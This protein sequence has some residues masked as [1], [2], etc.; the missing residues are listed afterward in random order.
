MTRARRACEGW[1]AMNGRRHTWTLLLSLAGACEATHTAPDP[2][3]SDAAEV[4]REDTGSGKADV[5]TSVALDAPDSAGLERASDAALD[6]TAADTASDAGADAAPDAQALETPITCIVSGS[7]VRTMPS[8]TSKQTWDPVQRVKFQHESLAADSPVRLGWRYTEDGRVVAYAGLTGFWF[9]HDFAYDQHG[10]RKD[11]KLSYPD[12]PNLS[13]PS[14][15]PVWMGT[16]YVH[17]YAAD[18]KLLSSTA[19]SYGPGFQTPPPITRTTYAHDAE[20]RCQRVETTRDSGS[21]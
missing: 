9:Q 6:A 2:E 5:S 14:P 3:P 10:N 17:V 1:L 8:T 19:T 18:G 7:E 15:A 20:G 11:F 13:V 21:V 4:Q 16:S 12:P